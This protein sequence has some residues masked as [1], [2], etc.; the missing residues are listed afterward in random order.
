MAAMAADD[1]TIT[2]EDQGFRNFFVGLDGR[3]DIA[4]LLKDGT[5]YFRGITAID[6]ADTG[7]ETLTIDSA[8][9]AAVAVSDISI[10]MFLEKSRLDADAVE[11]Q[12]LTDS[13]A[14]A[15][16]PIRSVTQ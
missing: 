1:T 14:Q 9:D 11:I 12:W 7:E 15:A 10:A 8:F 13:I 4:I 5:W 6:A 2:V 3:Q 16:L